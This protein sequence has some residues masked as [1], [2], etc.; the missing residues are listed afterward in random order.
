MI[1]Y[2]L[3]PVKNGATI[4]RYVPALPLSREVARLGDLKQALALY[5]LVFGQP[6]QE[7][8]IAYLLSKGLAEDEIEE[9]V[10]ELRIDLTPKSG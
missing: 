5:R 9:L 10:E 6:R 4:D 7:D 8:L 2:W 3:Y 1:P